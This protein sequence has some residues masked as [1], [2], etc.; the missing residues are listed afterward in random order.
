MVSMLS[1]EERK[2]LK[3]LRKLKEASDEDVKSIYLLYRKLIDRPE[4]VNEY[5]SCS[6][7]SLIREMCFELVLY[8]LKNKSVID[9][10]K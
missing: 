6:C 2:F 10:N 5:E 7:P 3:G 1:I 8:Y 9:I 4:I